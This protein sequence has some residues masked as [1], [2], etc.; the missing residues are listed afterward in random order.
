MTD[1]ALLQID[2]ARQRL[3]AA[4]QACRDAE[5]ALQCGQPWAHVTSQTAQ[6][7]LQLAREAL[8]RLT[9]GAA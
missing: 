9:G 7:E 1:T 8:H 4:L 3:N 6:L 5:L 2:A